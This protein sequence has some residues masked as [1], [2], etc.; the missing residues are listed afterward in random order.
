MMRSIKQVVLVGA[1]GIVI[2][3]TSMP[4]DTLAASPSLLSLLHEQLVA[5]LKEC[6]GKY[7]YDPDQTAGVAENALAP[8]E[9]PW[10]QCAYDAVRAYAQEH[11]SLGGLYTQLINEDI[12]MTTAIQQGTLTRSERRAKIEAL[13]T[14]IQAA[15]NFQIDA[16]DQ[17]GKGGQNPSWSNQE[18]NQ[19]N[20]VAEALN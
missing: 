7:G 10:R 13:L 11:S 17:Q 9:L 15:E 2:G 14:E 3:C 8:N 12:T 5:A 18:R 1:V 4:R 16:A 6:T 20:Y 19:V